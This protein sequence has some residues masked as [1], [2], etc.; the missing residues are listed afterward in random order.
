MSCMI[1][2]WGYEYINDLAYN[3]GLDCVSTYNVEVIHPTTQEEAVDFIEE[4]MLLYSKVS[5][6]K[7]YAIVV[8][9]EAVGNLCRCYDM[10]GQICKEYYWVAREY[11]S[12]L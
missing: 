6:M 5:A 7:N 2:E 4:N 10:D 1:E 3:S 8:N 9:G 12:L 11:A